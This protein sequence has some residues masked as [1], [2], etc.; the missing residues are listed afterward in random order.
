MTNL[1]IQIKDDSKT[2]DVIRFLRDIDFLKVI[3]QDD[4]SCELLKNKKISLK[5]AFGIWADRDIKL[6]EI[7]HKAWRRREL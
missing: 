5:E 2:N 6:S 3:I 1:T 7:R 4:K